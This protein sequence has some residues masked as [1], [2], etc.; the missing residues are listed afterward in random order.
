MNTQYRDISQ[1]MS[2][3]TT[4]T[5]F[6]DVYIINAYEQLSWVIPQ[7]LVLAALSADKGFKTI[8][9]R[10]QQLPVLPLHDPVNNHPIALVIEALGGY[11][12]FVLLIDKM[13]DTRRVRISSLHDINMEAVNEPFNFQIVKME[14]QLFQVPDFE[15]IGKY[16]AGRKAVSQPA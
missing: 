3:L 10:D 7:N 4:T 6:V 1:T 13:P 15:K 12:R 8:E 9:W 14:E 5:G 2:L 16:I 11:Q